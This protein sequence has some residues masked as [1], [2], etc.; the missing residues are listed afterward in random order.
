MEKLLK[1]KSDEVNEPIID[2]NKTKDI[3]LPPDFDDELELLDGYISTSRKD[4][5]D[6]FGHIPN[7]YDF[8]KDV[9]QVLHNFN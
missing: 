6:K 4:Y 2:Y 9:S 5:K 8:L 3:D 7:I 1:S